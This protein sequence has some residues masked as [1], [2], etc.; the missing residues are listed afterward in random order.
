M[1]KVNYGKPRLNLI[2][3]LTNEYE[4]IYTSINVTFELGRVITKI[5]YP[6]D[7]GVEMSEG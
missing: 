4:C 5:Y 1:I 7:N 3:L 6:A 2:S